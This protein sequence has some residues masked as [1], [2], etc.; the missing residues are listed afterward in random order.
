MYYLSSFSSSQ[1]KPPSFTQAG[2]KALGTTGN[3]ITLGFLGEQLSKGKTR[4]KIGR[5]YPKIA[6]AGGA[7]SLLYHLSKRLKKQP[8]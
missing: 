5:L 2:G 1:T 8:K 6:A 7:A 3:L 4:E